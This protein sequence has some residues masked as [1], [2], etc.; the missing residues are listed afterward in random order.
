MLVEDKNLKITLLLN[1]VKAAL[2]RGQLVASSSGY[3][4]SVKLE[5][6]SLTCQT[7]VTNSE[8]V[9]SGA[10]DSAT[11]EPS[12]FLRTLDNVQRLH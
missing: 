12:A 8:G 6:R 10:E 11:R 2:Q 3:N 9:E 7:G 5:V 4:L 1:V